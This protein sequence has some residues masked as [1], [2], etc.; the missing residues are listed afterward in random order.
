[1]KKSSI[2]I[3]ILLIVVV[4]A[5]SL[6]SGMFK[7][8]VQHVSVTPA[9]ASQPY[10]YDVPVQPDSPWPTFRRDRRNTG[11]S[12]LLASYNGEQPWMFQTGKGLFTTPV[13][14]ADGNIYIGSADHIFYALNPDGSLNWNMKPVKLSTLR[15][16]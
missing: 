4:I 9:A 15:A 5:G 2:S 8:P 13:I 7:P 6:A 10:G 3:I 12:P 11:A 1:M 16:Q 14:D